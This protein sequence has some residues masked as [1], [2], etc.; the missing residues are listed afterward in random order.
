MMIM[1]FI[2]LPLRFFARLQIKASI[3]ALDDI[4]VLI[5]AVTFYAE[6]TAFLLG[7][8][9][10][11]S[12]GGSDLT[13]MT[14]SQMDHYFRHLFIQEHLFGLCN[15]VIKLSIL[16]LYRRI[17]P[18]YS[19]KRLTWIPIMMS[20][21]W[22]IVLVLLLIFQCHPIHAAWTMALKVTTAKCMRAGGL[23]VGTGIANIVIDLIILALP[24]YM[25]RKSGLGTAKKASILC[26]FL[27]GGFVCIASAIRSYHCWKGDHG[28]TDSTTMSLNW[29]TIELA[30]ALI[31][32]SMPTYAPL[33]AKVRR[34]I[35][36]SQNR[37]A[38]SNCGSELTGSKHLSSSYDYD[39]LVD[40]PSAS[41]QPVNVTTRVDARPS[42][43]YEMGP[44]HRQRSVDVV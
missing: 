28:A 32:A 3:W 19:F 5:A 17:F 4:L 33:F 44:I 6:Q 43:L 14:P 42:N 30:M 15:T 39:Q 13:L 8:L 40:Q 26:I 36:S 21:V 23:L 11:G 7:I 20:I 18:I 16:V 9:G 2:S 12:S 1:A 27:L 10:N 34:K 37:S 24:V 41:Y 38:P 35:G 29:A 22:Y 25:V 31:C